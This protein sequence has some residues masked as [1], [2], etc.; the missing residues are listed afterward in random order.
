MESSHSSFRQKTTYPE[1][2]HT[3]LLRNYR[4]NVLMWSLRPKSST[5]KYR[6]L[7]GLS[8]DQ[9]DASAADIGRRSVAG[10]RRLLLAWSLLAAAA[11][12][13]LDSLRHWES[14]RLPHF[15]SL[16]SKLRA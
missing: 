16:A 1:G 4:L 14:R 3:L 9:V 6:D 2:P 5:I 10:F 11:G 12:N 7:V 13:K 15:E 8:C